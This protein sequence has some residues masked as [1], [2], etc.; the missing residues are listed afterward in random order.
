M[1][2]FGLDHMITEQEASAEEIEAVRKF[3]TREG[4]CLLIGPHHDVGVSADPAGQ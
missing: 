4:T 3:L 1:M 2:V